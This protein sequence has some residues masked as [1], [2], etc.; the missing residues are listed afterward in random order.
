MDAGRARFEADR[1][2]CDELAGRLFDAL[3][4]GDVAGLRELL[5]AFVEPFV[6]IGGVVEPHQ[7]N[8]QPGVILRHRDARV[9][10]ALALDILDGRIQTI[11]AVIN[12]DRLRH[13]GPVADT[14][15]VVRE[16]GQARRLRY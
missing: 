16:T 3:R 13:L 11:R 9:V 14:W 5:A 10:S 15:A 2:E 12:P 8:G 4:E 6:R 1:R 7:V